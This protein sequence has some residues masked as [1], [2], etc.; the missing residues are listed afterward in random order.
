MSAEMGLGEIVE[1]V[2]LADSLKA[3]NRYLTPGWVLDLVRCVWPKGIDLDPF[4]DPKS[5][6]GAHSFISIHDGDDA[7]ATPWE[8]GNRTE[9][10]IFANGPYSG[11][12]PQRT[13]ECCALAES[14]GDEVMN[15]C[16]AAPGSDYWAKHVWPRASAIAW[17]GRLAFEAAIDMHAGD[18][19]LICKAGKASNGNRTEIALVYSGCQPRLFQ[20]VFSPRA[21]V[22]VQ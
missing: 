8:D 10:T 7:Y 19:R 15:L 9:Y 18:G 16:P 13:A 3:S 14:R 5:N 20:R 12:N 21:Y 2:A 1:A 6:V 17:M 4:H 22:T 11:K